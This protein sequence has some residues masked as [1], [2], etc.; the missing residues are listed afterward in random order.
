M[1]VSAC[2]YVKDLRMYNI[3]TKRQ[4]PCCFYNCPFDG[5]VGPLPGRWRG[6][7]PS[8]FGPSGFGSKFSSPSLART[9]GLNLVIWHPTFKP[10]PNHDVWWNMRCLA[11]AVVR[12][13][14]PFI[15]RSATGRVFD[16]SSFELGK[17]LVALN[18]S[19]SES[20]LQNMVLLKVAQE[21]NI[22]SPMVLCDGK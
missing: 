21:K 12:L 15:Y 7:T 17:L 14:W 2:V 22:L 20:F 13:L 3:L 19:T 18:E 10:P 16:K 11:S 4:L 1:C 8:P 5:P 6:N 9:Y